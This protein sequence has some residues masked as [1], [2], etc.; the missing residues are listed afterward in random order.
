MAISNRSVRFRTPRLGVIGC[1]LILG[2]TSAIVIANA[3]MNLV[4]H[5]HFIQDTYFVVAH[6]HY[7]LHLPL[8]FGFFAGWYSLFPRVTG[9]AYSDTLGRIHFWL[10]FIGI[11]TALVPQV[12]LA[13]GLVDGVVSVVDWVR[14]SNRVS[15]IGSYVSA[16]GILAF[17][18]TMALAFLQRRPA[19]RRQATHQE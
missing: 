1:A 16:A 3:R 8:V 9:L 13:S 12:L 2:L 17:F 10:L 18:V 19:D 5:D 4:F 7:V 14:Y 6:F 11:N 15:R